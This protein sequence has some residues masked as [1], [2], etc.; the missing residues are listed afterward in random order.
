MNIDGK[1]WE[2]PQWEPFSLEVE[3]F[4]NYRF[5]HGHEATTTCQIK[6]G[7]IFYCPT[8]SSLMSH[9]RFQ[10]LTRCLHVTDPSTYAKNKTMLRYDKMGKAWWLINAIY[11]NCKKSWNVGKFVT[12][13]EIMILYKG[14]YC[15]ARQY[16]T[17]KL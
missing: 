7:S 6:K 4:Y 16:M 17:Q 14:T 15:P 8:I 1:T 9:N 5:V 10:L 12:I 2:G 11:E 3:S 13:D